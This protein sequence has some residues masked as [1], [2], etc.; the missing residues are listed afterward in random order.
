MDINN[1]RANPV[2]T[3]R[4][5]EIFSDEVFQLAIEILRNSNEP[6]DPNPSEPEIASVRMLSQMLGF[7]T[8]AKTLR[9]MCFPI[10]PMQEIP[11]EFKPE[12]L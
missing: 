3:S 9:S 1:F 7:N 4:L 11:T 10:T 5:S 6:I 12:I 2:Y 8:Y